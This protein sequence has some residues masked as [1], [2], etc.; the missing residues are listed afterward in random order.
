MP[1]NMADGWARWRDNPDLASEVDYILVHI[2]PFW[3]DI[4]I[5]KAASYVL[6]KYQLLKGRYPEFPVRGVRRR[7]EVEGAPDNRWPGADKGAGRQGLF[8]ELRGIKQGHLSL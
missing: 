2:Y 4:P 7:M 1:K 6:E 8:G 5:D 3:D